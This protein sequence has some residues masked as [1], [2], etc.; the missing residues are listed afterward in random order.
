MEV[1]CDAPKLLRRPEYRERYAGYE[2][3]EELLAALR[4]IHRPMTVLVVFGYWCR[5]SV[6]IVPDVLKAL[7]LADNPDLQLLAIHVSYAETDPSPF[8]A[9]PIPV[10]R[11]PTIALLEGRFQTAEEIPEGVERLRFV[12]VPLD[13]GQIA[14][15]AQPQ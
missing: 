13:A 12:E 15:L 2:P 14:A 3:P 1:C 6:R 4:N 8:M 7:A 9:G 10:R 11:Y 5:D